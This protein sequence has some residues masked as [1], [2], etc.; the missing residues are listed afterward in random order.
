[1]ESSTY[2]AEYR[3]L[4]WQVNQETGHLILDQPP[5]NAMTS[6]FFRDL[7]RLRKTGAG[8]S[9]VKA[10][11][12]YGSGRHFSSGAELSDLTST[13]R[14]ESEIDQEG[15]IMKISASVLEN[16]E[17]FRYFGNLPVPVI[18][19]IRGVC[20][21]SGLELALHCHF[22]IATANAV[23]ALPETTYDLMPGLG[24][25]RQ[26]SGLIPR[27]AAMELVFRGTTISADE[28]L[29]LGIIDR[30]IPKERFAEA[31]IILAETASKDY[32]IY[33][34]DDYLRWFD[35]RFKV[36]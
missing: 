36:N 17:T 6:A 23:L 28:G 21:G 8:L 5:A 33:K 10:I 27:K 25:I 4:R 15:K 3:T 22:R 31:G 34:K 35:D 20:L 26:L 30:I 16:H 12:I 1:M 29:K 9:G 11:L 24:G 7:N 13:I 19:A 2:I 18:A 32:R 14:A